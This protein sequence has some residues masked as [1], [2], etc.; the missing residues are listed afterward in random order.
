MTGNHK[1]ACLG[2][3]F[4]QSGRAEETDN[5][6]NSRNFS[7][8]RMHGDISTQHAK[9]MRR[10]ADCEIFVERVP[11]DRLMSIRHPAAVSH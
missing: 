7:M 9:A 4:S 11:P 5:L 2:D 1:N 3:T 10:P 6:P 8:L